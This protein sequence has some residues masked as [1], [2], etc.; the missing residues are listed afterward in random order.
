M[1][2]HFTPEDLHKLAQNDALECH[3]GYA[4]VWR[5]QCSGVLVVT[6]VDDFCWFPEH[7]EF[8]GYIEQA[9]V[10]YQALTAAE[11]VEG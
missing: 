9:R 11:P 2:H 6:L 8:L 3:P 5:E 10:A 1:S 7:Y 4:K